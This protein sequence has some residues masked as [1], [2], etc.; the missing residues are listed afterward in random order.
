MRYFILYR[1]LSSKFEQVITFILWYF[2]L[3]GNETI[4]SQQKIRIGR[5]TENTQLFGLIRFTC[6][7]MVNTSFSALISSNFCLLSTYYL[8]Y[9][10][11][12]S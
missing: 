6:Y 2:V 1:S 12:L 5:V 3:E 11:V 8:E 10:S 7:P 9:P 4:E